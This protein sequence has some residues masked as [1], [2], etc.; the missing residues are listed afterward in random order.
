MILLAVMLLFSP[1]AVEAG[2]VSQIT[3]PP[4]GGYDDSRDL[5]T[6]AESS[7]EN[8]DGGIEG[9]VTYEGY[10]MFYRDL[11]IGSNYT[12]NPLITF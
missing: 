8:T 4:G 1:P 3:T 11:I 6:K 5:D 7:D 9:K 10:D 12:G 2:P